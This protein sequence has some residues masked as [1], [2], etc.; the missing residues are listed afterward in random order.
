MSLETQADLLAL[1][2][3][4]EDSNHAPCEI[5]GIGNS[6]T[7]CAESS[8]RVSWRNLHAPVENRGASCRS[9]SRVFF[10]NAPGGTRKMC[11]QRRLWLSPPLRE[12]SHYLC[13]IWRSSFRWRPNSAFHLQD[14]DT[15][16]CGAARRSWHRTFE[17]QNSSSRMRSWCVICSILRPWTAFLGKSQEETCRF[18]GRSC[19]SLAT[20]YVF[21]QWLLGDRE[22]K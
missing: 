1:I 2:V 11:G 19:Y 18:M 22:L 3:E 15:W 5:N 9:E 6:L 13:N 17:M 4:E 16:H 14:T 10:L 12:Q 20:S 21:F 7:E 8:V